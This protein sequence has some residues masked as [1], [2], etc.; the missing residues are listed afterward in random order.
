M[1]LKRL[2]NMILPLLLSSHASLDKIAMVGG[3][4]NGAMD[5]EI[6][7]SSASIIDEQLHQDILNAIN[8]GYGLFFVLI[9]PID[10]F[11]YHIG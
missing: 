5:T 6:L 9:Q 2:I 11:P 3:G 7:R 10:C 1:I 4:I 8:D